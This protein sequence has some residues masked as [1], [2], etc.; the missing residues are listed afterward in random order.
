MI[1]EE[2]EE[3][4]ALIAVGTFP[5]R[6]PRV[7]RD[8]LLELVEDALLTAEEL[9]AEGVGVPLGLMTSL[10][11]LKALLEETEEYGR[12]RE[13]ATKACLLALAMLRTRAWDRLDR[14][15]DLVVLTQ[16]FT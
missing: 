2:V 10:A 5:A 13:D 11:T 7:P 8:R 3:A 16:S 14:L 9:R 15:A 12:I 6:L 4:V 1:A